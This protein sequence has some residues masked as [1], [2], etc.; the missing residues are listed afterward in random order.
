LD[1]HLTDEEMVSEIVITALTGTER[2]DDSFQVPP[3]ESPAPLRNNGDFA[4]FAGDWYAH[5]A[6]LAIEPDG[7]FSLGF[8]IYEFCDDDP[9]PCD[10]MVGNEIIEGG[11][12]KGRLVR[13][14]D[15]VY[16][17][18]IESTDPET[19]PAGRSEVVLDTSSDT[20]EL[21]GRQFCGERA[22]PGTCGA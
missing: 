16:A 19:F 6:G 15:T 12:A 21:G 17:L 7:S 11:L 3:A 8:R 14:L 18:I 20:L 4:R 5:G 13:G 9:P 22:E 10:R 1:G 2:P